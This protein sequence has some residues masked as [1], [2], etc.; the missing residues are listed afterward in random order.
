M[1][2]LHM[3]QQLDN[4]VEMIGC[5]RQE[6]ILILVE[7]SKGELRMSSGSFHSPFLIFDDNGLLSSYDSSGKLMYLR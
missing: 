1:E 7:R 6:F 3:D 2:V 4:M 5:N